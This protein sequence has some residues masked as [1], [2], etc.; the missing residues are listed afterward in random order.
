VH[1]NGREDAF[2]FWAGCGAVRRDVFLEVGGFDERYL[3]PSIE[4]IELGYRLKAAGHRIRLIKTLYCKHLKRWT[5]GRLLEADFF[6]RALPWTELI[7]RERQFAND[8]NLDYTSRASVV[9]TYGLM[10]TLIGG[11]V[12][13][14]FLA[15]SGVFFLVLLTLNVPI[16][17]FFWR[18]RGLWFTLRAIFWHW[19]YYM[20]CGLAF[21]IGVV[22]Y[23]FDRQREKGLHSSPH[24]HD[25]RT[26]SR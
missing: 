20:Y 26:V 9:L 10:G 15:L 18:A 17:R 4:D 19:L 25:G 22:R 7:L 6:R 1:Q 12:W 2:T 14:G 24:G 23:L 3:E 21:T 13:P 11:V 8:L 5:V 16:Y